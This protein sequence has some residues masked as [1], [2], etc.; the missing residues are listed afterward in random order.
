MNKKE[1]LAELRRNLSGLPRDELEDKLSFYEEMI[2]DRIDE[3]KSE[4]QAIADIGTTDEAVR[5]IASQTKFTTLVKERIK[6]KREL[7]GWEIAL[8]ILGFPLWFPLIMTFFVLCFIGYLL[9][10]VLAL[11]TYAI[12]AAFI[13]AFFGATI[14]LVAGA[15]AGEA[16]F[17]YVGICAVMFGLACLFIFVCIPATK[18]TINLSKRIFLSFKTKIIKNG[19]SNNE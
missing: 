3:G 4:E 18:C 5:Q 19:G 14:S 1:F 7:K 11:V 13:T 6:P 10:W 17:A 8:I 16:Q 9:V 2:N 12:E 15:M